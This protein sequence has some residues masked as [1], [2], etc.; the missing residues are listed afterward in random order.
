MAGYNDDHQEIAGYIAD[1]G[2]WILEAVAYVVEG[3]ITR[4]DLQR[5]VT[6]HRLIRRLGGLGLEFF[7]HISDYIAQARFPFN[8]NTLSEDNFA[9]L[10]AHIAGLIEGKPQLV[11][12]DI[13]KQVV[14][15][16][17]KDSDGLLCLDIADYKN[18]IDIL[19][20]VEQLAAAKAERKRAQNRAANRKYKQGKKKV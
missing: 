17:K 15:L 7:K 18:N 8:R 4:R 16:S 20:E 1:Y 3:R 11:A 9:A 5:I 6:R 19:E 2:G 14:K 12:E 13:A 10:T